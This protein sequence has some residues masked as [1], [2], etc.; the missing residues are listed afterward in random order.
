MSSH[1]ERVVRGSVASEHLVHLF[2]EPRSL[3]DTVATYLYEGWR[4][5]DTLMVV[6]QPSRWVLTSA[7]LVA[8]GCPV[9][10]LIANGRLVA[11]D[12][13]TTLASV[14]VDGYPDREKFERA[15][16][17]VV[18]RACLT[19]AAGLTIFGEM[20]DILAGQGNFIAAE[21][22]E[23]LWNTLSTECSFRLLC[24]YSAGHFKDD[25]T[26]TRLERICNLHPDRW[27]QDTI[28]RASWLLEDRFSKY[29][30]PTR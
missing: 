24:A 3:V 11:L 14:M 7:E 20:V 4:R 23:S 18:R 13:A 16:G 10:D 28:L 1:R 25:R 17:D 5:G 30:I 26:G 8:R 27:S 9:G 2:D 22:L 6:A 15:V 12:A 29:H 21:H 19:S